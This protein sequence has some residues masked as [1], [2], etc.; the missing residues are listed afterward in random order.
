MKKDQITDS[1][2]PPLPKM[3][4]EVGYWKLN[5]MPG[6]SECLKEKDQFLNFWGKTICGNYGKRA[7]SKRERRASNRWNP[8]RKKGVTVIGWES[9][10]L[11]FET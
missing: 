2:K 9:R 10:A 8:M 1:L 6:I 7:K 4:S 11:N 3:S 5:E